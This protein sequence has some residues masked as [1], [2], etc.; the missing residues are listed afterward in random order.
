MQSKTKGETMS[1]IT[2]VLTLNLIGFH[3]FRGAM[4]AQCP[5]E[6]IKSALNS[7]GDVKFVE[8][9]K[10]KSKIS[11][12]PKLVKGQI[13]VIGGSACP[14]AFNS[15]LVQCISEDKHVIATKL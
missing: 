15:V 7:Y 9:A 10:K 11:R 2:Q 14:V 5:P 12:K 3:F 1:Q 8:S 4:Y 6:H 13:I